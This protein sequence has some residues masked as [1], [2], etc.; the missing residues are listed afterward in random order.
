MYICRCVCRSIQNGD[1]PWWWKN[2]TVQN[3]KRTGTDF[4]DYL[5]I[6]KNAGAFEKLNFMLNEIIAKCNGFQVL[7]FVWIA[8]IMENFVQ[9][10]VKSTHLSCFTAN[11][12]LHLFLNTPSKCSH[13]IF[14]VQYHNG[15][16]ENFFPLLILFEETNR[17]IYSDVWTNS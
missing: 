3:K 1:R 11:M 12:N 5:C 9:F 4:R 8:S 16:H 17:W 6:E 2:F 15:L 10:F 14:S 13:L 7:F